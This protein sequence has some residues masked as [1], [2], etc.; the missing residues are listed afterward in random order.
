MGIG[1]TLLTG[2]VEP[3]GEGAGEIGEGKMGGKGKGEIGGGEAGGGGDTFS[4][5]T[6]YARLPFAP[7][8]S[9]AVTV[10]A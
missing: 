1:A 4:I 5:A 7:T 8:A 3:G 2:G 9:V 6:E 10:K